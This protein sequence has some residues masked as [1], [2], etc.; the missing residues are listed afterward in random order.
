ME[1]EIIIAF[2]KGFLTATEDINN[3]KICNYPIEYKEKF[4]RFLQEYAKEQLDYFN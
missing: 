3:D 1:Q 2:I 4:N